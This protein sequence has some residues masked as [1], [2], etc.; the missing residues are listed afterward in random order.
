MYTVFSTDL[1]I[2]LEEKGCLQT[3]RI[4][5][6]PSFR[7]SVKC[8]KHN[9]SLLHKLTLYCTYRLHIVG[10]MGQFTDN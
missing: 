7:I 10:I 1:L 5:F 3:C 6:P 8:S 9:T 4:N 2:L